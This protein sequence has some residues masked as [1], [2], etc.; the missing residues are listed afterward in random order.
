MCL[1]LVFLIGKNSNHERCFE[2]NSNLLPKGTNIEN[3]S[4]L[5]IKF[6]DFQLTQNCIAKFKVF[7]NGGE[8]ATLNAFNVSKGTV[9]VVVSHK[10][11]QN[12]YSGIGEVAIEPLGAFHNSL[13]ATSPSE[14]GHN[15]FL[16]EYLSFRK[17]F[18]L[19]FKYS[20]EYFPNTYV[21]KNLKS[22]FVQKSE[23]NNWTEVRD[24]YSIDKKDARKTWLKNIESIKNLD[25]WIDI[26]E[27]DDV[28]YRGLNQ[29]C[30]IGPPSVFLV[31]HSGKIISKSTDIK[32]LNSLINSS[33]TKKN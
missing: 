20:N 5:K 31:H 1:H 32:K 25:N 3:A 22:I 7:V 18:N 19:F 29:I 15:N 16:E 24:H 2:Q 33:N 23:F 11:L 8:L 17:Q 13:L 14:A 12:G 28:E 26:A 4:I 27:T 21:S 9:E 30:Y 10:F 6:V